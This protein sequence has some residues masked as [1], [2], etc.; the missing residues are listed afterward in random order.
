MN[1]KRTMRQVLNQVQRKHLPILRVQ[2]RD[3]EWGVLV[4]MCKE[5][6]HGHTDPVCPLLG[7]DPRG[8]SE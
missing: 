4:K 3:K 5:C 8:A 6:H 7:V 1:A 2:E